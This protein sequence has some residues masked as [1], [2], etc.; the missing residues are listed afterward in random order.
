MIFRCLILATAATPKKKI[1]SPLPLSTLLLKTKEE[2]RRKE[3][4]L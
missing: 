4:T 3:I 2:E 1:R